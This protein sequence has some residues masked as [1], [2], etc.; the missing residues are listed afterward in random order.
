MNKVIAIHLHGTAFHLEEGGYET[1]RAYLD[2]ANRQL[3]EN[4]DKAEILADIEQAIADKFAAR[5]NTSRNV[6]LSTEVQAVIAEIGPVTNSSDATTDDKANAKSDA[7]PQPST[8]AAHPGSKKRLYRIKDGAMLAGVCNG[9]A[10]YIGIDVTL[11]RLAVAVLIFFSF[12]TVAIA[13]IVGILIIPKAETPE[14]IAAT[15]GPSPTAQEFIRK[16]KEG[17]YEGFKTMH[18]REAHRAWKRK[19]KNEMRD[20]NRKLKEEFRW[21]F[22]CPPLPPV[23]S[24]IAIPPPD[25]FHV[26]MPILA[27][28]R[29]LLILL[30][31][32]AILS[33]VTTGAIL[34]VTLPGQLPVWAGVI[35]L[36]LA[37]KVAVAPI[38]ALRRTYYYRFNGWPAYW[39]PF[40]DL[41]HG[42]LTVLILALGV[43]LADCF[44]PGFHQA[45][46]NFP[47]FCQQVADSIQQWWHQ[48]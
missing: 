10:T 20:W 48:R 47:I 9:L 13:Y 39:H 12:G 5:L 21:G 15:T 35:L 38:K 25:G 7:R 37:Y 26:V 42:L 11:L 24:R 41:L 30:C 46:L 2:N 22:P 14:Q 32:F 27:T 29:A 6:V 34:G 16:A 8:T 36:I 23:P 31:W 3:E 33:L 17:Y 45:L 18:D 40:A 19:F 28:L 44:I 1:L 43:W 4:P